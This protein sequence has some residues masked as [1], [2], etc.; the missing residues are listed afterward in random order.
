VDELHLDPF[1]EVDVQGMQPKRLCCVRSL[2]HALFQ[3][4]VTRLRGVRVAIFAYRSMKLHTG[5]LTAY[6]L[7]VSM[8]YRC[9]ALQ[10]T[11]TTTWLCEKSFT[12]PKWAI[13][14]FFLVFEAF[15]RTTIMPTL[16]VQRPESSPRSRLAGRLASVNGQL[17]RLR[18]HTTP[19][20]LTPAAITLLSKFWTV[21]PSCGHLLGVGNAGQLQ[22]LS[23][24]MQR[25][26]GNGLRS[27][28]VKFVLLR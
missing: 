24:A 10:C 22:P 12:H 6:R 14:H 3:T 15:Y 16:H 20:I 1:V 7:H 11:V 17:C 23:L 19:P 8:P 13:A 28:I 4:F 9:R 26:G 5:F 21:E 27:M 18:A 25:L 2:K